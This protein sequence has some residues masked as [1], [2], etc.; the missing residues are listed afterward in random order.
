MRLMR[1]NGNALVGV[2][3]L[4]AL[5]VLP[6]GNI[7]GGTGPEDDDWDP[8]LFAGPA[9]H[10]LERLGEWLVVWSGDEMPDVFAPKARCSELTPNAGTR[11]HSSLRT[12]RD[13]EAATETRLKPI[14]ALRRW[15]A[16]FNATQN[17]ISFKLVEFDRTAE[18]R[19][20]TTVR[21]EVRGT[22]PRR[23]ISEAAYWEVEWDGGGET[24][25]PR[26]RSILK[27]QA[28]RSITEKP[29]FSEQTSAVLQDLAVNPTLSLGSDYWYGRIDNLG[30]PNFMG[31]HGIA[32]G[33][34]DG[35]GLEDLYVATGTGLPNRLLI[36][37]PDG[38]VRDT[39]NSAGVAW[40]DDT[41]GVLIVDTD[42]D[43]DRD[44]VLAL[45]NTIVLA[46]NNGQGKFEHF[47][48]MKAP[49]AAPFYSLSA[50]D[51]DLDGD[52]DLYGVRYIEQSY[53]VSVPIP[54]HDA[55]NGPSNHLMRNDGDDRFVDVTAAVGLDRNNRRFS[56][57]AAWA[58]YDNDGDADLYVAND[59]GRNNLYRND[60]GTFT[61]VAGETGTQDQAAGMGV[62]WADHDSDGDFD[63]HV[64]NM[65]SAAGRRVAYQDRFQKGLDPTQRGAI[66][67]HSLGNS[68]FV[69]RGDGF[70]DHSDDAGVRMGRWGWGAVFIDW[71]NDSQQDLLV[72]NGFVS[73]PVEDDL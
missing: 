4:L 57:A 51:F 72:P 18:D 40:L 68:L 52:I 23:V 8:E 25:N 32:V 10:V 37:N 1:K 38:T 60:G 46:K 63:L 56:L 2:P 44:L 28:D 13:R 69:N 20:R 50:A 70:D 17:S 5:F 19:V 14:V 26:I 48:H 34:V 66:Q 12:I 30:E 62:A 65:Y 54:F 55:N 7:T 35:D 15:A 6:Y 22:G 3:L 43:G 27:R 42:N 45:G 11:V 47:V 21:V 49:T 39:A 24:G 59:F 41:K 61:D 64:T 71:D 9:T 67:R 58:D 16:A 53:G 29:L 73:G 33:D 31:H 36:R